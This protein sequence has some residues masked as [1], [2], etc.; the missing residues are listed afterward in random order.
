MKTIRQ[1][2]SSHNGFVSEQDISA[3]VAENR[4]EKLLVR[5]GGGRAI[6]QAQNLQWFIETIE[7]GGDYVRDVALLPQPPVGVAIR[8]L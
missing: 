3:I 5:C 2:R 8:R 4:F 6:V 7:L 1:I